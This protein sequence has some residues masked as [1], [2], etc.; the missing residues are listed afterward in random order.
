VKFVGA[1]NP[2][3]IG[4]EWCKRFWISRDFPPEMA[5]QAD[6]FAYVRSTALDNPHNSAAYH[7][8]LDSLPPALRG[9]LRDGSWDIFAGQVFAE[10]R[11]EIHVVEPFEIPSWWFR[12]GANDP[13]YADPG[14]WYR[15]AVDQS[16]CV[17]VYAEQT[18]EQVPYLDQ[19]KAVRQAMTTFGADDVKREKPILE[20]IGYWVTGMDAFTAEKGTRDGKSFVDYY[21]QGG[22]F[23]FRRPVHGAGARANMA[24]TV[25]E[26]LKPIPHPTDPDKRTARLRIFSSCRRLIETLPSLPADE[27]HPE[28]V[29]E[30]AIDHWYQALGYGLQSLHAKDS[31]KPTPTKLP[32]GT[33]GRL[34]NWDDADD[35]GRSSIWRR[36]SP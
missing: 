5:P 20:A 32:E 22:L 29:D 15:L 7:R 13:G 34:L 18:F 12:F 3:S 4:H 16:G 9:A 14:V 11:R 28:Q 1:T 27:L 25:H 26:Y 33:I 21:G 24:G 8:Q 6:E 31:T 2:G 36:K 35:Q 10:F 17:Y 23:G 30:C 19:A